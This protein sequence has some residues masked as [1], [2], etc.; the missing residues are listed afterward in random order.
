MQMAW[1]KITQKVY[2]LPT[3]ANAQ[4]FYRMK[5]FLPL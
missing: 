3:G 5:F 4:G 1:E 2:L